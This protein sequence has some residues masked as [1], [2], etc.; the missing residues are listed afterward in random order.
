MNK[1]IIMGATSG[2]G[3][4]V[5]QRM[6]EKGWKVG[7]CGRNVAS[8]NALKSDYPDNIFTAQ[9][10]ITREKATERLT[11]IINEMGGMDVYFHVS[12]VGYDNTE[13]SEDKEMKT[14]ET[15]VIGFARMI[16]EAYRYFRDNKVKGKIAAVTSVAGTKGIAQLA[17]YSSSKKFQQTYLTA[18]NQL[19]NNEGASIKFCDIRPGWIHTPLLKEGYSYPMEMTL[20][21]AVPRIMKAM[22][23]GKRVATVDW[24][25]G[26]L[27]SLWR[28][29]PTSLWVRLNIP[30]NMKL[31]DK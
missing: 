19:A 26:I 28:L 29:I 3:F 9:I 7:A 24:R 30:L 18:L 13:L 20:D 27:T 2:I 31:S 14:L 10:D 16:G 4:L 6:A 25:W 12:G 23:R 1:I 17:D 22:L 8:L 15:N 21:Y 11:A 5:A